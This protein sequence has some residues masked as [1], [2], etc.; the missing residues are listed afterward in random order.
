ME[1][2]GIDTSW[3]LALAMIILAV[4]TVLSIVALRVKFDINKWQESRQK[5]QQIK[6]RAL[7]S[8]TSITWLNDKGELLVNS[9][10]SNP[11]MTMVW[12]CSRCGTQVPDGYTPL[13]IQSYWSENPMEWIDQE[14]KFL[15]LARK[16]GLL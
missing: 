13:R 16:L 4:T 11:S 6:L 9:Y 15:K 14:K 12:I 1:A 8:H 10:F 2:V 3:K 5:Q 7:C